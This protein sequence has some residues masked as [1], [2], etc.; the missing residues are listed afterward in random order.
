MTKIIYKDEEGFIGVFDANRI[1]IEP[2]TPTSV[3]IENYAE[4]IDIILTFSDVEA[5]ESFITLLFE[6][7][8][9]NL[10]EIC[11]DNP[12]IELHTEEIDWQNHMLSD[13]MN[14]DEFDKNED[15]DIT[16][17]SDYEAE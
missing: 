14:Y 2:D 10:K 13:L 9:V 17:D 7:D 11:E 5:A 1:Y 15:Y 3:N 6:C 4:S 16:E 8:K 12:D